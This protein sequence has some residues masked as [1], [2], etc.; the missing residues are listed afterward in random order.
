MPLIGNENHHGGDEEVGWRNKMEQK[1][2]KMQT[3]VDAIQKQLQIK[4]QKQI[5]QLQKKM[6]EKYLELEA[7]LES[8]NA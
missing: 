3:A 4:M 6:M 7:S 8:R 1:V 5:M 2:A